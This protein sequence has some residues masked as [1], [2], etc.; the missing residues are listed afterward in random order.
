[1][2]SSASPE[3]LDSEQAAQAAP[4]GGLAH[5]GEDK[6]TLS[7]L[8]FLKNLSEKKKARGMVLSPLTTATAV[9]MVP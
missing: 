6:G 4:H 1:M 5:Q 3:F 7:S 8:N 2:A 9:L